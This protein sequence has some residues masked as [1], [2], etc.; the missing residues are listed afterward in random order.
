[1]PSGMAFLFAILKISSQVA[2]SLI[3][4]L[5]IVILWKPEQNAQSILLA[6]H[7]I[8]FAPPKSRPVQPEYNLCFFRYFAPR[9]YGYEYLAYGLSYMSSYLV[10]KE[11]VM[12]GGQAITFK[13]LLWLVNDSVVEIINVWPICSDD[14]YFT[15]YGSIFA[16]KK[17]GK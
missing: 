5:Y 14:I 13:F 3:L 12:T 9:H 4:N 6:I 10:C 8:K 2:L 11:T 15:L 1:M 17:E 16:T 7:T